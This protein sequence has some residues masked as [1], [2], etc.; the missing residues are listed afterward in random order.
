MKKKITGGLLAAVLLLS[1]GCGAFNEHE[2]KRGR[3]D[4]S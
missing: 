2:D 4:D 3:G 1:T